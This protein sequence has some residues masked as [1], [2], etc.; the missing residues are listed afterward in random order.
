[1]DELFE[2]YDRGRRE[3]IG[4]WAD[5]VTL[6]LRSG[7]DPAAVTELNGRFFDGNVTAKEAFGP[8]AL[9]ARLYVG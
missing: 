3:M 9:L 6:A 1:M 8:V 4:S 2:R 5:L 7:A